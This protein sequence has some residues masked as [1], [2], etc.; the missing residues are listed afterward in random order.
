M[1]NFK[2]GFHTDLGGYHENQ[3]KSFSIN[4]DNK[5]IVQGVFD[6][7]GTNGNLV[8][9]TANIFAI[10]YFTEQQDELKLNPKNILTQFCDLCNDKIRETILE[11]IK[12]SYVDKDFIRNKNSTILHGGTTCTIVAIIDHIL[13]TICLGDSSATLHSQNRKI[14]DDMVIECTDTFNEYSMSKK[15]SDIIKDNMVIISGDQ[16]AE[17][18]HEF[19]RTKDMG[20]QHL[21]SLYRGAVK[22]VFNKDGLKMPISTSETSFNTVRGDFPSI[23]SSPNREYDLSLT[24]ALGDFYMCQYGLTWKPI[25]RSINIQKLLSDDS[26]TCVLI[27]SDGVW[28]N[29][30]YEDVHDFIMRESCINSI[31]SSE[32]GAQNVAKEFIERNDVY[33][34]RNFGKDRDNATVVLTFLI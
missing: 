27:A 18:E 25:Y 29:W 14:T 5:I 6:G 34:I 30:K 1:I 15:D 12:G 2:I 9:T 10:T 11:K 21:Y 17:D 8:A 7:H 23:I 3:D 19:M 22:S 16:S 4:L 31:M 20:A 33:A 28:D 32:S 24:R 26:C 13:H